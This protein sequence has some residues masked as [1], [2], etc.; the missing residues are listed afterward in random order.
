MEGRQREGERTRIPVASKEVQE[1]F[2]P[3]VEVSPNEGLEKV[4]EGCQNNFWWIPGGGHVVDGRA[5]EEV[6]GGERRGE[7]E[8]RGS[9]GK[10]Q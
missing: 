4:E 10:P 2:K 7:E 8:V 5:W 3:S 9:E 6:R 1:V